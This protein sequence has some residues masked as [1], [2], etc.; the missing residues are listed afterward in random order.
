MKQ[1]WSPRKA[2]IVTCVLVFVG[3]LVLGGI[4]AAV[5]NPADA[6]ASGEKVGRALLPITVLAGIIAYFVQRSRIH[7]KK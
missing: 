5:T 1:L 3:V 7:D 2:T 4:W 6:E